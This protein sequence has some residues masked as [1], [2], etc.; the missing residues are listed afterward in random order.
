MEAANDPRAVMTEAKVLYALL[1][2]PLI[3]N[4]DLSTKVKTDVGRVQCV[5]IDDKLGVITS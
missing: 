1:K 4:D 2:D 3:A 5:I